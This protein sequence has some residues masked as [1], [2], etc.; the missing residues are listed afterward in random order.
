MNEDV[1][2][3]KAVGLRNL[4]V[5]EYGKLDLVQIYDIAQTGMDDLQLFL[6]SILEKI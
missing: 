2:M 6:K 3:T 4:I 5:H 1:L